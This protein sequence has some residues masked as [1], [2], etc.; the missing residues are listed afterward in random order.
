MTIYYGLNV[1]KAMKDI[2]NQRVALANLGLR[3]ENLDIIRQLSEY[4]SRDEFHQLSGLVDN[5]LKY[6]EGFTLAG[7]EASFQAANMPKID[8][9]QEY[10]YDINNRLI[11]GTIK[12]NYTDFN[13]DDGN[14]NPA[15]VSK[16]ADI[17]TSRVSSWSPFGP[18]D[19]PDQLISYGS[20]VVNNGEFLALTSLGIT[21]KPERRRFLSE[22]ATTKIR[23]N[24][25]GE[26][27]DV[28]A[29]RGIPFTL[30][31]NVAQ[32]NFRVLISQ[33]ALLTASGDRVPVTIVRA[34]ADTGEE[35]LGNNGNAIIEKDPR[36]ITLLSRLYTDFFNQA[37][38]SGELTENSEPKLEDY[39]IYYNPDKIGG[40]RLYSQGI[41][42]LPNVVMEN[43]LEFHS[44]KNPFEYMPDFRKLAP[45]LKYLYMAYSP[46]YLSENYAGTSINSYDG[47]VYDGTLRNNI[48][49]IPSSIEYLNLSASISGD[50]ST[51]NFERFTKLQNIRF[52]NYGRATV[53][54]GLC[55]PKTADAA[56]R[57]NFN[58][59]DSNAFNSNTGVITST[60][61][62]G[63]HGFSD[64]DLVRYECKVGPIS[65]PESAIDIT[66]VLGTAISPLVD[67]TNYRVESLSPTTFR[68]KNTDGT[69]ITY[70]GNL[71]TGTLHTVSKWDDVNDKMYL[72]PNFGVESYES[73]TVS[74]YGRGSQNNED[75]RYLPNSIMNSTN[76][77]TLTLSTM[78][79]GFGNCDYRNFWERMANFLFPP[80]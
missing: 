49:R 61:K 73:T 59:S 65:N 30:R 7:E 33:P 32:P 2:G 72:E 38:I 54:Y 1:G 13:G 42:E 58:P 74:R 19:N 64:N 79:N 4:I 45:R 5:Q 24:I 60:Q 27:A 44:Y 12:Y 39:K 52:Q 51:M 77:D 28:L 18:A 53:T 31:L 43:M 80:S 22:T 68:L 57:C 47:S 40:L 20:D 50:G 36:S 78:Q 6:L 62:V 67:G 17:S 71:G 46:L 8:L 37:T 70:S 3:A 34:D 66:G 76:L 48:D 16:G 11:A 69:A 75:A 23:L 41:S 26:P 56:T 14:G 35:I 9:T 55:L 21:T 63:L 10:N 25:N 15:W 29:M